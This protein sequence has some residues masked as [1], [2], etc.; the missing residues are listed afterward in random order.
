MLAQLQQ[1]TLL[2]VAQA[3]SPSG[4]S[5]GCADPGLPVLIPLFILIFYFIYIR[6]TSQDR[7]KQDALLEGLKRGDEVVLQS[8]IIGR[9]GDISEKTVHLELARNVKLEVL[10]SA[11]A[12]RKS[13]LGLSGSE[14]S[15]KA[16]KK[17]E[18]SKSASSSSSKSTSTSSKSTTSPAAAETESKPERSVKK[19]ERKSDKSTSSKSTRK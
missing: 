9:I 15:D 8:G 6:P 10:K 7:K 3:D 11:I 1:V 4:G 14:K 13:D 5:G 17:S 16:E 19:T 12:K 2:L 18:S